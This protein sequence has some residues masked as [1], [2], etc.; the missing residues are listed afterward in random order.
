MQYFETWALPHDKISIQSIDNYQFGCNV[1]DIMECSEYYQYT[2]EN[3]A[4]FVDCII[5][6]QQPL[7][8]RLMMA[9]DLIT[10]QPITI[11][12]YW[13]EFGSTHPQR[14]NK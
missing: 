7:P 11:E 12:S 4:H 6:S 3:G 9:T 2:I 5:L 8:P 1:A 14:P 13:V 10:G